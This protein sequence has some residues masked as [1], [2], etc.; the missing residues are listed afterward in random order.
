[1]CLLFYLHDREDA[2]FDIDYLTSCISSPREA[3]VRALERPA[4]YLKGTRGLGARM[5]RP[6]TP[7]D[8]VDL[9]AWTDSD[10]AGDTKE[11]T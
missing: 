8:I 5:A 3:D 6:A 7:Q 2:Q 1:M 10:W 11:G 9:V 4:R